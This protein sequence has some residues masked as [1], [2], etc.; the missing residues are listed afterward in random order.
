MKTVM[1]VLVSVVILLRYCFRGLLTFSK[2]L[3]RVGKRAMKES[4]SVPRIRKDSASLRT[5][6][7]GMLV[8]VLLV[9]LCEVSNAQTSQS[10]GSSRI[11][12]ARSFPAF[13]LKLQTAGRSAHEPD[14]G[15]GGPIDTTSLQTGGSSDPAVYYFYEPFPMAPGASIFQLGA[16]FSLLPYP[17]AEQELP[18]PAFD[19]QYKRGI[20]EHVAVVGSLSTCIYSNLVHAGIQWNTVLGRFSCGLAGHIG[21]A[22]GFITRE[23]LFD[24]VEGYALF[25]ML[26]LRLGYRFDD[27]SLS[28]SLVASYVMSSRTYVNGLEASAGPQNTVNDYYC[29]L[30]VE[31]P[32]LRSLH[33]S[34]GFSLGYARTPYQT[35][36][37]Y[38]TIDE[39]LFSPEFFFAVQL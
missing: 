1:C 38:N 19:V 23:N 34:V 12:D 29:T 4:S 18:I 13:D 11:P 35:W 10:D 22:Y 31:Q 6:T 27:F 15:Y 20:A 33:V 5:K 21:G 26:I 37:L 17:D 14:H 9:V 32:F 25:D 36:M 3:R 8:R 24:D 30:V 16:S 7:A 2:P 28:C 39:W